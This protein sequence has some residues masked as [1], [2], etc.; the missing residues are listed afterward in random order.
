MAHP[1]IP[2]K[3][4]VTL[5]ATPCAR[6]SWRV[7]PFLFVS[8]PTKLS[9]SKLSIKP[10]AARIIAYGNIIINVSMFIGTIG[11]AKVGKP[12]AT[13]DKS[14]TLGT[15]KSKSKTKDV[16]NRIAANVDGIILVTLGKYQMINIVKKTKTKEYVNTSPEIH[17]YVPSRLI[18]WN[19]CNWDNPITIAKPFTKPNITGCGTIRINLPNLKIPAKIWR[20]PIK[21]TVAKRY[22]T[23]CSDTKDTITTARAPVAPDI[24][25]GRPPKKAVINPTIKAAYKPAKGA[26]PAT[27]A[28]AIASGTRAIATVRPDRISILN[29][30]NEAPSFGIYSSLFKPKEFANWPIVDFIISKY[31]F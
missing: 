11:I 2:P 17:V 29:K 14:P 15:G 5:L 19:W 1:P 12:P 26:T 13:L 4:P 24:I 31:L 18:I 25:P 20:I 7:P 30:E 8:S 22:C 27:K 21:T 28:N 9:V 10:I 16:T 6:H 3:K 23:P